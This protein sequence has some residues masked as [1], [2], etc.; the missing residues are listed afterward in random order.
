MAG[1][2]TEWTLI[3]VLMP[4]HIGQPMRRIE[5]ERIIKGKGRYAGDIKLDGLLHIAFVRSPMPHAR[6]EAIDSA[7]AKAMPGVVAVWTASDLPEV[8]PG[9]SDFGPTGIVQHGR[10]ILTT[11]EVNYVGEAYALVVA[12]TEYEARDAAEAIVGE[13]DPLPGVGDVMTATAEGAP[14]VHADMESN[15]AQ[16]S[17]TTFGDIKTA[18]AGDSVTAQITL[19][20]SRVLGIAMEPRTVTASY[21]DGGLKVWTSTQNIF[22]VRNTIASILG[23][24]EE[25]VRVLA[26]DVGG[27]FGAKGS[28]FPEEVLTALAA[29][30]LKRPVRWVATR[31]EDGATTA[32]GHGSV[33]ELELAASP[34]GKL[35][36]IRGRVVHDIGAYSA[37]GAGQPGIIIPHMVS[38]YVLPAMD[39]EAELIYTNT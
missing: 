38:A 2:G 7:A 20:T 19:T 23:L 11:D 35:R 31:S 28:V 34:D 13:L 15:I 9:L 10:P 18:F 17:S 30:R 6:I 21:E 5:D 37:S 12:E 22:G 4:P 27:G 25:Q 3:L 39:I 14:R 29:L 8:T 16:S 24:P 1:M 36:G 26:E 33:I 32:Q